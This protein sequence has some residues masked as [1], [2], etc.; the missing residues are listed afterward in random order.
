[1][2]R[3]VARA[4]ILLLFAMAKRKKPGEQQGSKEMMEEKRKEQ[5]KQKLQKGQ[6]EQLQKVSESS[7]KKQPP[8]QGRIFSTTSGSAVWLGAFRNTRPGVASS[9][10]LV[11]VEEA[12]ED[13]PPAAVVRCSQ[14]E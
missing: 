2:C 11:G 10:P 13:I 6:K 4:R 14:P 9:D 7:K 1:S 3:S 8:K 5:K 12:A